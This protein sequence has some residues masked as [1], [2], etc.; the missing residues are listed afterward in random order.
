MLGA[1]GL[2]PAESRLYVTL[3]ENPRSSAAELATHCGVSTPLA[4]R[5]LAAFARRGLA[6]RLPGRQARYVAVTPDIAIRPLLAR[7]EE[8]LQQV[9]T[10]VHELT[11]SFHLAS[12]YA[13][14]PAEQVEVVMGSDNIISRAYALQDSAQSMFRNID[15]PPYVMRGHAGNVERERRMLRSGI[16]YRSVYDLESLAVPGKLRLVQESMAHGEKA[17]V[18]SGAAAKM[19]IADDALALIPIRN[20]AYSIDAAFILH[21]SALLDALIALFELEWRRGFPLR[22]APRGLDPA[23]DESTRE[24]LELLAG[25]LTDEAIARALGLGLR[26]VQR[27]IQAVM[28]DLNA[29]TRFQA[30]LAA[31]ERGWI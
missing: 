29:I 15:K 16:D 25:G 2:S 22:S 1:I 8:E 19:W 18:V 17:R 3:V 23:P 9:R 21:R 13:T 5:T 31:R 20:G 27:R 14:H 6:S 10:A 11:T 28:Q 26:T 12:R 24:L 30:G 4:A 7:R